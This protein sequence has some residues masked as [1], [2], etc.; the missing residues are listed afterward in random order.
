MFVPKVRP[1]VAGREGSDMG[2]SFTPFLSQRLLV[3][4]DFTDSCSLL[5]LKVLDAE[6]A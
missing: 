2:A 3:Q 4:A 5:V 6:S 1:E